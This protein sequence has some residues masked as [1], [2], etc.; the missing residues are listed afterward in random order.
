MRATFSP[1]SPGEEVILEE[2]GAPTPATADLLCWLWAA[3]PPKDGRLHVARAAAS[4]KISD[5]TL[6]RWIKLADATGMP[7]QARRALPRLR[8]L[9]ALRGRGALLWPPLDRA[10]RERQIAL[11]REAERGLALIIEDPDQAPASWRVP[12]TL[13]LVHYPAA[14]VYGVASGST[15]DTARKIR[16]AK[17]EIVD[18][19]VVRNRHAARLAKAAVL[20]QVQD[21]RC[22][23][24]RALV[25][26]GRTE[27]WRQ[28]AGPVLLS[29]VVERRLRLPA[30][31]SKKKGTSKA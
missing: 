18:T 8:Q 20:E 30:R 26:A 2:L 10:S 19:L 22:I 14:R 24:P 7:Q 25:P 31:G 27:T 23:P 12:H 29:K 1:P 17:G 13:Y 11:V 28:D 16:A 9:A 5:S 21:A 15:D 3:I 6:R 4:L